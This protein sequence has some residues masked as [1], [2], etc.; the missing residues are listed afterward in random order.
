MAH[1]RETK[2]G[3][4][5]YQRQREDEALLSILDLVAR[6]CFDGKLPKDPTQLFSVAIGTCLMFFKRE[7]P[8]VPIG[9]TEQAKVVDHFLPRFSSAL[10]TMRMAETGLVN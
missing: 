5:A 2:L 8:A 1:H 9:Y 10:E 7:R 4:S 6:A 3:A